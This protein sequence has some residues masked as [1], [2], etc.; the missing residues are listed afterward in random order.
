[1]H[2][3]LP[4]LQKHLGG[5]NRPKIPSKTAKNS[6]RQSKPANKETRRPLHKNGAVKM[7]K[8]LRYNMGGGL[9]KCFQKRQ[10]NEQKLIGLLPSNVQR[11]LQSF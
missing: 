4:I 5:S 6:R 1:V 9:K 8:R 2:Q 7:G 11:A 3:A 10:Q